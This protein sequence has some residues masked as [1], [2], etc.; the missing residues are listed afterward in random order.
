[1]SYTRN[2]SGVS[3]KD[4]ALEKEYKR[5]SP[6]TGWKT[7]DRFLELRATG[8]VAH[9]QEEKRPVEKVD[10]VPTKFEID[11]NIDQKV[12]EE[13]QVTRV[14]SGLAAIL[15]KMQ[16]VPLEDRTKKCPV[17]KQPKTRDSYSEREWTKDKYATCI[18]CMLI[19]NLPQVLPL[20]VFPCA[21][22]R[23]NDDGECIVG[24][25]LRCVSKVD[26]SLACVYHDQ[27]VTHNGY[28]TERITPAGYIV[29]P[30]VLVS[31]SGCRVIEKREYKEISMFEELELDCPFFHHVVVNPHDEELYCHSMDWERLTIELE[32][33]P[34]D[35]REERPIRVIVMQ[36][37]MA[38]CLFD[39]RQMFLGS[40]HTN[41]LNFVRPSQNWRPIVDF[42]WNLQIVDDT[43]DG[44][45]N[46]VTVEIDTKLLDI[47][48][49]DDKGSIVV[50][51]AMDEQADPI[52]LTM[53]V[54][55]AYWLSKVGGIRQLVP[56]SPSI[57][58]IHW[59]EFDF[60][61]GGQVIR[62]PLYH[63]PDPSALKLSYKIDNYVEKNLP[64]L[65]VLFAFVFHDRD[66]ENSLY[67]DFMSGE[68]DPTGSYGDYVKILGILR[69]NYENHTEIGVLLPVP[70]LYKRV[71]E[72]VIMARHETRT[73]ERSWGR[74]G[75]YWVTGLSPWCDG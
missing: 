42:I 59:E 67:S 45:R 47:R 53:S 36:T 17:C 37:F 50:L 75:Y 24:T 19:I 34:V 62:S 15:A 18:A 46:C 44:R 69:V 35:M 73:I 21:G 1:M 30:D 57:P 38:H 40:M 54:N 52:Q 23:E 10:L 49:N 65:Q 60:D 27:V 56:V 3:V 63:G 25:Q 7:W 4:A 32:T 13:M 64:R 5:W 11:E 6:R 22:P 33:S 61:Y 31:Y 74:L 9:N 14:V 58:L 51:F 68:V 29:D 2:V 48:D 41:M 66:A 28:I 20:P 70:R 26:E 39:M 72:L 71:G 55:G 16:C 12:K 8:E 43:E